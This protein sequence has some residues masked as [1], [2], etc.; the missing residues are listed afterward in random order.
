MAVLTVRNVPTGV[1]RALRQRAAQ[2][3]RSTEAEARAILESAVKREVKLGSLIVEIG[4]GARLTD[5]EVA[6][7]E[8]VRDRATAE[9]IDFE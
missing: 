7:F 1:Y 9:P 6:V 8:E 2:H 5:K 3:G 4:R